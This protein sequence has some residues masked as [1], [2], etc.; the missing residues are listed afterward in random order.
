MDFYTNCQLYG[1]KILLRG[2]KD[3][4]EYL[5]KVDY[6]PSLYVKSD[7]DSLV[8]TIYGENLKEKKFRTVRD[9]KEFLK[10]NKE[11]SNFSIFGNDD[12]AHQY[13]CKQFKDIEYDFSKIKI[14]IFDIETS[15]SNRK[16]PLTHKIKVRKIM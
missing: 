8:K 2:N 10:E 1:N 9:A 15:D 6:E 7:E 13:A 3:G 12:L 16:Y 5:K 4:R 11:V 14:S